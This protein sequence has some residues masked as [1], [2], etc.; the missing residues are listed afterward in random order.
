M[1]GRLSCSFLERAEQKM[2][3]KERMNAPV[4]PIAVAVVVVL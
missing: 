3:Q 1:N 4:V 2:R